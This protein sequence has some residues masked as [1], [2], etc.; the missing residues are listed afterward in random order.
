MNENMAAIRARVDAVQ[1]MLETIK[2]SLA[3]IRP[4]DL[5]DWENDI[6]AARR[7]SLPHG[8]L[9]NTAWDMLIQLDYARRHGIDCV[10][11]NRDA[12]NSV[13]ASTQRRF[14]AALDADGLVSWEPAPDAAGRMLVKLTDLGILSLSRIFRDA[15]DLHALH[16]YPGGDH[17]VATAT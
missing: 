16:D 7:Q 8:Y 3:E 9:C 1:A 5:S 14:V 17:G 11:P 13:S 10:L 4:H 12:G 6:A 15:A 2:Q